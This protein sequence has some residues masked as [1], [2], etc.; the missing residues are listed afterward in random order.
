MAEQ[1]KYLFTPISL[2]P[3]KLRNRIFGSPHGTRFGKNHLH[4]EQYLHYLIERAKGGIA[5]LCTGFTQVDPRHLPTIADN[6]VPNFDDSIIPSYRM[7]TDALHK[8]GTKFV[9][10][11]D[12]LGGSAHVRLKPEAAIPLA[13]SAIA[14]D[15]FKEVPMEIEREEIEKIAK[16][17]GK[18]AA[19]CKAGGCDG[20]IIQAFGGNLFAGFCSPL[21]NT[22]T[23]E[24]GGPMENRIK[25]LVMTIEE[26]RKNI[27]PEMALGVR[28]CGDEFLEGGLTIDD[29]KEVARLLEETGKV[30]W[31][32]VACMNYGSVLSRAMMYGATYLPLGHTVHLAAAIREVV[33]IPVVVAGRIKDPIQAEKILADGHA[34][35]VGMARAIIADPE[36]PNKAKA[37]Q[38]EDIRECVGFQ[39]PCIARAAAGEPMNCGHNPVVG[40]E[41]EW[42]EL[43]PAAVKKKV[44]VIGGGPGGMEAARVAAL[45]GHK[46]SLYEKAGELGGQV[47]I[48]ARASSRQ[49][50]IGVSR[51]LIRQIQKL[52]IDV[53]L[54]TEVTAELVLKE[55]PD[56]VI[57]A[58]GSTPPVV[59]VPGATEENL[60]DERS[61]LLGKVEV[62]QRV[63]VLDGTA[64]TPAT[65]TAEF[66]AEQGKEV[67]IITKGPLVAEFIDELTRPLVYLSLFNKGVAM[68]PFTWIKGISGK[69]VTTYNT[70]TYKEEQ[71]ENID[72][73]VHAMPAVAD[74]Q[75]F[76]ALKGKVK[77]VYAVG[78]CLAPRR[79]ENAIYEGSKIAREI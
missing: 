52:D 36:L 21:F 19:R 48:L 9:V 18:S 65:S 44:M 5:V 46:V 72:T 38:L 20:V 10:E 59:A 39:E 47:P 50:L 53:H 16:L 56:T 71:M 31:L 13:P 77:E 26:V 28:I 58:T 2:G 66:L 32:D 78:D 29:A 34:D 57:V 12:D 67:Y 17:F 35:M 11:L 22:R 54:N 45:R 75:L 30:D 69:T 42:A 70:Y 14:T 41:K 25:P 73:V 79:I 23:D 51:W 43:K 63:V 33:G 68:M 60:V 24:F 76:K 49:E 1:F 61:V 55:N 4:N 8:Y 74:N 62:G 64:Y 6:S 40:R 7:I 15:R 27:G 37:G 3:M